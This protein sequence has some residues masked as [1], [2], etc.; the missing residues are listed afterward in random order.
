MRLKVVGTGSSGNCYVLTDNKNKSLILEAGMSPSKVKVAMNFDFSSIEGVFVTHEHKDHCKYAKDFC[1]LGLPVY[2]NVLC[3]LFDFLTKNLNLFKTGDTI[4]LSSY[5]VKSFKTEHDA[6]S[7]VGFFI[8]SKNENKNVLFITDSYYVK[9]KFLGTNIIIIECNYDEETLSQN[10]K[11]LPP[12][13]VDRLK[14]SHMSLEN[15]VKFTKEQD[16]GNL[17]HMI[18]IHGSSKNLNKEKAV[19]LLSER[20]CGTLLTVAKEGMDILL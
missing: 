13:Y 17:E 2:S 20:L 5:K 14:H 8:L 12:Q 7:P 6:I 11:D 3:T 1:S 16:L 15:L 4:D 19:K 10:A 9:Y 18:L